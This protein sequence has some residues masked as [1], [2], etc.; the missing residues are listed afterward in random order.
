MVTNE[1]C[2]ENYFEFVFTD[3]GSAGLYNKDVKDVYHSVFGAKEEAEQKFVEPLEFTENYFNVKQI[4]VLDICF[5]IG[6]NTKALLKKII[7]TNYR[8]NVEID[9][10][11]QDK[12]LVTVSPFIK[13]GFYNKFPQISYA[14]T[15]FLINDIY[16]NKHNIENILRNKQNKKFI[17]PF[18][19]HLIKKY[20]NFGYSY[21]PGEKNNRFLHNIHYQC[22]SSRNKKAPKGLNLKNFAFN[23]YYNDARKVVKQLK[24]KYNIIFLDAFTPAK[25]PTLW[26]LEFFKEL[27][28]VSDNNCMLVTYSNS[29]AVR[30]AMIEAG[31]VVGKLFDKNKRHCGTVASVNS[32]LIKNKLDDYDIGLMN[33]RAGIYFKDKNLNAEPCEILSAYNKEKLESKLESSSSYIKRHKTEN[34]NASI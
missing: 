24:G 3:D 20:S 15:A 23:A 6:Y 1:F 19:R 28:R 5:G 17:E 10:I 32:S 21:A 9:I 27:Y 2:N 29:I 26:T 8:G 34:I 12:N 16:D 33:T 7:S 14:M 25:L 30:H 13:D 18:Y 4:R 31:F 11:E 22:I